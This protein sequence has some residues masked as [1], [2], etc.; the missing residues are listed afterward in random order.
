M[1]SLRISRHQL[2][3]Q[4]SAHRDTTVE[5]GPFFKGIGDGVLLGSVQ[6]FRIGKVF[7]W[8][9]DKPTSSR[10]LYYL[11]DITAWCVHSYARTFCMSNKRICT[12][13][14]FRS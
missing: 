4:Q 9:D 5:H 6:F 11:L 12:V 1:D 3:R 13:L 14:V 2:Q 7:L 10:I 8:S